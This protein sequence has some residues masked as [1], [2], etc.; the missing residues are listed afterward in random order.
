MSSAP[1]FLR[2]E[3]KIYPSTDST[4]S[5]ATIAAPMPMPALAPALRAE[6]GEATGPV[7]DSAP[8]LELEVEKVVGEAMPLDRETPLVLV[9]GKLLAVV[10]EALVTVWRDD[11]L[12]ES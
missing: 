4:R 2:L 1:R 8:V 10:E 6:A 7:V 11:E 12:C 3:R 5:S 9:G